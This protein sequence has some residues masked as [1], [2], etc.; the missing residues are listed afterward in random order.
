MFDSITMA[1]QAGVVNSWLVNYPFGGPG[2]S[3]SRKSEVV[4][5]LKA[6]QSDD[7][8]MSNII[9]AI[10]SR[11]EGRRELR[12]FKLIGEDDHE[13]DMLMIDDD[14][15]SRGSAE[16]IQRR[17]RTREESE[18]ERA[19]RRR[20]REAMVL[21]EGGR[22]LGRDDIIQPINGPR[23]L[24]PPSRREPIESGNHGGDGAFDADNADDFIG[25]DMARPYIHPPADPETLRLATP[26]P[27][28]Q[29][30]RP[31]GWSNEA[32]FNW[33]GAQLIHL[34]I[35]ACTLLHQ[36]LRL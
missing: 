25:W 30:V 16:V 9:K 24:N 19:L 35:G 17:R 3:Q 6:G 34:G 31:Q 27:E 1:L 15:T 5:C 4:N 10:S 28:G 33:Q 21:N 2:A 7:Y 18:E 36:Q 11:P 23:F 20:R 22:P 32:W 29:M 8:A 26:G 12:H 14:Y 13:Y